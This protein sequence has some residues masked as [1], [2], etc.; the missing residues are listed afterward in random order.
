[1]T[2]V[3]LALRH[4]AFEDLGTLEPLLLECNY[5]VRYVDACVEDLGTLDVETPAL[6]CVLGGPIGANDDETYPC[7]AQELALVR[8][9]I[10]AGRP[11]LGICLGAQ[12][13]ARA[14]GARVYPA[15]RSEIGW[16]PLALSA[17]GRES[18][19]AELGDLRPMMH[20][21]GDTF[22]IP[23]GATLLAS[24]SALRNQ[25]FLL[26]PFGLALQF[27]AEFKVSS[28][29]RWLVGH[30]HELAAK[31]FD[32]RHL[33]TQSRALGPGLEQ[34]ARRMFARWLADA[35]L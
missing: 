26:R 29:E 24:T 22:D 27:H 21:H 16:E 25:A 1:M 5:D 10:L 31:K 2:N 33:R 20:W 7:V 18:C 12:L 19:L 14:A 6:L 35:G 4:V 34:R 9:R 8:R 11:I 13:M 23:P 15:G 32:V 28:L 17:A 3:V 30:A